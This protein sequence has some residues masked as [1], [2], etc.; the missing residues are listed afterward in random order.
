MELT[1]S[2]LVARRWLQG[3]DKN[4]ER[5]RQLLTFAALV[6]YPLR[7]MLEESLHELVPY[8]D[9]DMIAEV[10]SHASVEE[11]IDILGISLYICITPDR[12]HTL[13]LDLNQRC[14]DAEQHAI[15]LWIA[16]IHLDINVGAFELPKEYAEQL[17]KSDGFYNRV[18]GFAAYRHTSA[19]AT[20]II[21]SITRILEI[22]SY[23]DHWLGLSG[24]IRVIEVRGIPALQNANKESLK[25]LREV[26]I[27]LSERYSDQHERCSVS[28][29]ALNIVHLIFGEE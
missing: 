21:D 13:Y 19:S 28:R 12:F 23:D 22:D 1:S 3:L 6:N 24:T 15:L 29:S 10:L 5:S 16:A 9:Q 20:E 4:D 2:Q 14:E 26:L 25:A 8:F 7:D 11:A 17:M 27:R 18:R